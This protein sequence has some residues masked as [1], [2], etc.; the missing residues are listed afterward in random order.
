MRAGGGTPPSVAWAA[1]PKTW[2]QELGEF[3]MEK[4]MI[5]GACRDCNFE[6]IR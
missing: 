2:R 4:I 3:F 1:T 6:K 5:V